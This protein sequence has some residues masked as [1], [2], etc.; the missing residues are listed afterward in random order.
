MRHTHGEGVLVFALFAALAACADPVGRTVA[1]SPS[2]AI[3]TDSTPQSSE[4]RV[5]LS[6]IGRLVAVAMDNEPA[7]QHLK[8]D[9]R[10][11]PFREHKV[12]LKSY[13]QSQDG[14]SLLERM[15]GINGGDENG[16]FATL[17]AVR[18]LE[19]YMPV[20]KH[21][22]TWKGK[23]DVLV[24]SQLDQWTPIVAFDKAGKEVTLDRKAAPTRPTLSIV[25]VETRFDQPMDPASSRNV[26]DENGEAIGTLE[27]FQIKGSSLI[28]C[29]ETCGGGG[30]GG[31]TTVPAGL[32]LEFSRILD[33]KE[34]WFRGD[35]EIEVHI[36]GPTDPGNPRYGANKSCSGEHAGD[37]RKVFNQD[38]GFWSGRVMLYSA[39]EIRAFESQFTEGYHVLFWEDDND[40]CILKLDSNALVALLSSTAR[41]FS[42]VA[43]KVIPSASWPVVAT[44]FLGTLF[45]NAGSWLLTDDDFLG[46]AVAQSSAGNNYPE[47]THVIM[48]G[49]T[50]NGRAN[51]VTYH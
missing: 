44:V 25:P 50:L 30:T 38:T 7:R 29:G 8:R 40:P 6:R 14:K 1:P 5:A 23:E 22:E 17:A 28:A 15:T 26:R 33:V 48:D 27:P 12:E 4:E 47:N 2:G 35:P 37:Y 42:T 34:P 21:R 13:L 31:T 43:L 46:A 41:A 11:A 49:T 24:V 36:H 16:I 51:I 3:A 19:L 39:D 32:Y 18:P 9:L 20:A 10:A 45:E